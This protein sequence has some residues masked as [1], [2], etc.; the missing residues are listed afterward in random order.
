[1]SVGKIT[2]RSQSWR[3]AKARRGLAQQ[4]EAVPA[5]RPDGPTKQ[6]DVKRLVA[7]YESH[8]VHA[9]PDRGAHLKL[10][11]K[12]AEIEAERGKLRRQIRRRRG[13]I[14]RTF[15]SVLACL[16]ELDYME[17]WSLTEKG[18]LLTRV[19]NEADLLVVESLA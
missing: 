19:Y 3:S 9:C 6:S 11:T 17:G 8:P 15:E 4:L 13:T 14:G 2:V 1:V 7:K 10:A 5:K 16:R 18:D 12:I